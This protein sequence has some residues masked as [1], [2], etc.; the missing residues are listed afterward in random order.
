[1]PRGVD[2]KSAIIETRGLAIAIMGLLYSTAAC[3]SN[4]PQ[5][6]PLPNP[7]P[8]A[9]D[10][11]FPGVIT[12]KVDASDAERRII[13]VHE[14]IP[15]SGGSDMVLFYPKWLPGTHAPY[16]PVDRLAGLT[17]TAGGRDVAWVRDTLDMWAFHV[18]PPVD[19]TT[20]DVEFQFLAGPVNYGGTDFSSRLA[21]LEWTG[22]ALYPAGYFTRNIP[23]DASLTVP[24]GW[25]FATA[26]ERAGGVGATATFKRTTLE[27]LADS[28]VYAGRYS[29]TYD[30]APAGA[31][32][33]RL[34][35]FADRPE[36]LANK[37]ELI[38]LHRA[39][40]VQASKLFGSHHYD[41]YDFLVAL[42]DHFSPYG[43]EHHR[44]SE[45]SVGTDYFTAWDR[46]LVLADLLAH[47]YVHSWNGKF[48]RPAD[49]WTPT[50]NTP[51]QD[52]L[53]W[54]YEGQ[55]QYWGEV[56]AVR[57]GL[58]TKEQYLENLA[59]IA[60]YYKTLPARSWRPLQDTTNDE[61]LF[62]D[63]NQPWIS[64]QRSRDYY[65][66][67]ALIWL[68]ADTLIR[69][70]SGGKRSLDDFA[71]AFFGMEDGRFTPVTYR[72][73]DVVKALNA[74]EPYDWAGFLRERLDSKGRPA[75]LGG[76][77]RGGYQLVF[78]ATPNAILKSLESMSKVT[79]LG[80]SLGV[81]VNNNGVLASVSWDGPAFKAGLSRGV[82]IIAVNGVDFDPEVL[83]DAITAAKGE[84]AP[85][86]LIVK[87]NERY[88]TVKIAYHDGLRYPHLQRIEGQPARLD[89][90]AKP[91]N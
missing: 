84:S 81:D 55:T 70:R 28:P 88:R 1:M 36:N 91:R 51:M 44:S 25:S 83:K 80:Y 82:K 23:V 41:H 77:A 24:D 86:E 47:E 58:F 21:Q 3:A 31:A 76:L 74:V 48:R 85:I 4:G 38:D 30:L 33:V 56:L 22:L 6:A 79:T 43:V 89:D 40:V 59:A 35:A 14:T 46:S 50:F 2:L 20:L 52:S 18:R 71:K 17:L 42:S 10:R 26:L 63:R 73:D 37:P 34:D 19:A 57:A 32:P 69:E 45:D 16:G 65:D 66:E 60:A 5:P 75:P 27:T 29:K 72:F 15:V 9:Q 49:L 53:L 13:R 67:G 61:I 8:A 90:I 54:V 7:V 11:P 12:L 78:T 64:W 87:D 39:L 68:D 62:L